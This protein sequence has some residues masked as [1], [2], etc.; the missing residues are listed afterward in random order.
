MQL[1]LVI[2]FLFTLF[3]ADERLPYG[4]ITTPYGEILIAL[5]GATRGRPQERLA[6]LST[7]Q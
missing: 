2:S 5:A 1:P 6:P 7:E 3:F 4:Q